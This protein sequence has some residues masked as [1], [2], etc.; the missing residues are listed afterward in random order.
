MRLKIRHTTS[1]S[2]GDQPAES[3]IQIVR[4][5]PRND[6]SQY[7]RRWRIEVDADCRLE[8]GEDAFGNITHMFAIEGPIASLSV[9]IEGEVET[10]DQN[11][12]VSET[13]ERFPLSFW[14]RP[15]SLT[16]PDASIRSFARDI[17][18]SEGGDPLTSAHAICS[19]IHKEFEFL[20]GETDATTPASEVLKA[21]RGVCQDFAHLFIASAR[22][23]DLP[24]RYVSGYYHLTHTDSQSAGH[25]W[26]ELHVTG[27][28]WVSF[29]PAN[30]TCG[31]ERHVRLA[32]APDYLDAPIRGSRIGGGKEELTVAV[33]VAAARPMLEM[34]QDAAPS[35]M[36]QQMR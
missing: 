1:Y 8:K 15:S 27:L 31:T 36:W 29:D 10:T 16:E 12:L 2:Y 35:A 4:K 18:M 14:K 13:S 17:A 32:V 5:T 24:A 3:A 28:G 6:A 9:M 22:S 23:L 30:N 11:G 33:E 19:A 26:A 20:P 7:V 34:A 25:A 21:R